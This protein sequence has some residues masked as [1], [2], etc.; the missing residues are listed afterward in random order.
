VGIGDQK[1][2]MFED[3]RFKWLGIRHARLVVP[4]YASLS[5]KTGERAYVDNWL[6]EARR[7]RVQPVVGFG[8]GYSGKMRTYLPKTAEFRRAV[9]AFRKRWPHV[10]TFIAWNEANHCSQPTCKRPEQAA[11]YYNV[12]KAACKR[13]TVTAP[14]VLDQPNMVKWLKRF[15]RVAKVQPKIYALHNYLDVNRLRSRGTRRL[16]RAIPK[17]AR[18][19]VAET[20]GVVKRKHFRNKASFPESAEHAGKVTTYA[21]RLGRKHRQI[22]RIYLYHWDIT[23]FNVLWDSGLIDQ[24]GAARPGFN[25]LARFLGRNPSRAPKPPA[26]APPPNNEPPIAENPPPAESRPSEPSS[27]S[28]SS[29]GSGEQQEPPPAEQPPPEECSLANLC[30]DPLGSI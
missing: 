27:S 29:G 18:V 21:L 17:K 1:T 26:P 7:A 4:W 24:L 30:I 25:S 3:P 11:R 16:L 6:R 13:C 5:N 20:G 22:S 14:A 15:R 12:I 2:H 9:R 10:R 23:S 8:H 19:W 28:G